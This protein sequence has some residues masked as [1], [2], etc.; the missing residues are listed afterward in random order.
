[1]CEV[2]HLLAPHPRAP[3]DTWMERDTEGKGQLR[4]KAGRDLLLNLLSSPTLMGVQEVACQLSDGQHS[5]RK[6]LGGQQRGTSV[7]KRWEAWP[8]LFM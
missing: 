3:T 7:G 6:H 2:G 1:M 4:A 8:W 5:V